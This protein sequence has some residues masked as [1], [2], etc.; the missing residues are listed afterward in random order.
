[1]SK[2]PFHF[3]RHYSFLIVAALVLLSFLGLLAADLA[4]SRQDE[5]ARQENEMSSLAAVLE[6][7]I[8]D[9]M[10]KID[11]V[12]W[13]I[14]QD[15]PRLQK[16]PP[17]E[18]N[19]QLGAFLRQIPDSQ[20]LRIGNADG[21]MRFDASGEVWKG[22][23]ADRGYY[24]RLKADPAAGLVMSEPIFARITHNWVVT[25]SRRLY[26]PSGEYVGHVQAAVNA[27]RFAEL[28]NRIVHNEGDVVALYDREVR[29]IA[30]TPMAP[31]Q[32]GKPIA[33]T[34]LQ[35]LL[36]EGRTT[37]QY[38]TV[39]VVDGVERHYLF[40]ATPNLPFV[41]LVGKSEKDMLANWYVKARFY[42]ISAVLLTLVVSL[43][44]WSWQKNYRSA[45]QSAHVLQDKYAHLARHASYVETHD[46][47][48][49]LPNRQFLTATLADALEGTPR[50]GHRLALLLVDL[51]QFKNIND[52][53]GHSVGD[54]LLQQFADRLRSIVRDDDTLVRLGGDEYVLLVGNWESESV[55]AH[56]AQRILDAASS[57]FP[58]DSQE[59]HITCSVG[60]S[61]YPHDGTNSDALLQ[62]AD[63]ALY[64]AKAS[65]RNAYRFF[66]QEMNQRVGERVRLESRLRKALA[67]GRLQL[68]YQPQIRVSD[69]RMV[70]V[71]ALLRW[72]DPEDG[73]ISP[74]RFIPIAEESGLI[75]PIGA[76][77]MKEA[78]H[79]AAAWQRQ[80]L[81]PLVM[82]VN[83]S[84]A[85]LA[86]A[87]LA[88]NVQ[89]V[90]EDSGLAPEWLELEITE[91]MLMTDTERTI[92]CLAGIR[93]LGVKVA[94]DD[95]GTGY[96]SF[97]YLRKLPLD[98][99][100]IDKSF[101]DDV[102]TDA[103]SRAIVQAIIGVAGSLGLTALAEGVE[104]QE[105]CDLL[106]GFGCN[107][108]QGYLYSP[109]VPAADIARLLQ[110][111]A[112]PLS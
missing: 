87:N 42:G 61:L 64:E 22:S 101:V 105:Q 51:D 80:G 12:L 82:A 10:G 38:V 46:V 92:A 91:S 85:Q 17:A 110:G 24:Q 11:V 14:A 6:R 59:L 102:S 29:L 108:I 109:A 72:F 90:L 96:S 62:H 44:I 31:E 26:D 98:K 89:S 55:P 5:I 48:T 34:P 99:L 104:T 68:H 23:V 106:K 103:S 3:L 40:R 70:G 93:R 77:V 56:M 111:E 39:S 95:F 25:L 27:D 74:A 69:G 83:L 100:K 107:A 53:L 28:F 84:V 73:Y 32:L 52:G 47:L 43:L 13:T 60:I 4:K 76:W 94:I 88:S 45:V 35:S 79:Q 30:R 75:K 18:V 54:R 19:A 16:L 63:A 1:M 78:C 2:R 41:I 33:G 112:A 71:E 9:A 15:Y 67:E 37:G 7:H 21:R 81:P 49:D 57:P 65:G 66:T 8:G 50:P 36:N 86:A 97:A 20:S 58:V